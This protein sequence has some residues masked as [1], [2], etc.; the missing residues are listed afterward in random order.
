[1][2]AHT[3]PFPRLVL[4]TSKPNVVSVV[5]PGEGG[6]LCLDIVFMGV[7]AL[8]SSHDGKRRGLLRR[9][10]GGLFEACK[11]STPSHTL[12]CIVLLYSHKLR[13]QQFIAPLFVTVVQHSTA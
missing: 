11:A 10:S 6:A 7:G 3:P 9:R 8:L 4:Y 12:P 5:A 13:A 2:G 1:M